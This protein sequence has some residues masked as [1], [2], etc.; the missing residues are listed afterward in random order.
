MNA[1]AIKFLYDILDGISKIQFHIQKTTSS[2]EFIN[3]VTVT[4]AVERR[5]AIIG[6]ALWKT[7]KADKSIN[8]TGQKSIIALRH[9]IVHEYDMIDKGTLWRIIQNDLPVLQLEVEKILKSLEN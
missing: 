3:D 9:I 5:L 1:E 8:V 6:E 2:I 4:D 7:S